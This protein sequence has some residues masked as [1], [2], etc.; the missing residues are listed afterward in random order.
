[1]AERQPPHKDS[2]SMSPEAFARQWGQ[3][4]REI[5]SWCNQLTESDLEQVAGK[6]D[7]LVRLVQER[8]RYT[9]ERA[10]QEVDRRLQ[11]YSEGLEV[12]GVGRIGEAV[13]TAAQIVACSP[14]PLLAR[15]KM[16]SRVHA[17]YFPSHP[18]ASASLVV[19]LPSSAHWPWHIFCPYNS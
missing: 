17:Y 7:Q 4:R 19:H 16:Q 8:Y 6:K 3:V 1:M 9:R 2:Q 18:S 11:E 13:T 14:D 12:S 5:T 15:S 10:Q